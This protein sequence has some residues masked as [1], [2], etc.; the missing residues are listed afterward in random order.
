MNDKQRIAMLEQ[1]VA[2]LIGLM[3][4]LSVAAISPGIARCIVKKQRARLRLLDFCEG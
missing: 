2:G 1:R 3:E 4:F